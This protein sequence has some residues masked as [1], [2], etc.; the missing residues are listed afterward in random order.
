MAWYTWVGIGFLVIGI[1]IS[2]FTLIALGA[3]ILVIAIILWLARGTKKVAQAAAPYVVPIAIG[4]TTAVAPEFGIPAG[5]AYGAYRQTR[6]KQQQ[7]V[8]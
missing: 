7:V 3:I 4:A 6:Q 2:N 5:A 1:L 8:Y